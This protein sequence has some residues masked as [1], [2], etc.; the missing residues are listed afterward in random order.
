MTHLSDHAK[1][2]LITGLGVL[3]IT[4]DGLLTR[5]I[6]TDPWTLTFWRGLLSGIGMYLFLFAFYR[7][8]TWAKIRE[9]GQAGLV[10]SLLFGLGTI[11]FIFALNYTTVANTLFILNTSPIFAA[12]IAWAFMNEP[13][14]RRTWIV[15]LA[16]LMGIA[17]IAFADGQGMAGGSLFGNIIALLLAISVAINFSL[18]RQYKDRDMLPAIALGGF[19][20]ALFAL[21]FAQPASIS[22]SDAYYLLGMGLTMLPLSFGLMFIG[23]RYI[24][25]AEVSLMM[26]LEAI[27]GPLWVWLALGENPGLYTLLGGAIIIITL[28]VNAALTLVASNSEQ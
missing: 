3:V 13:V 26:L 24:P 15:I 7:A 28:A 11:A 23:P 19:V 2:L 27:L 18:T 21:P 14:P 22:P 4:P 16:V 1:G 17:I 6:T 9:I 25:A 8:Q 12:L 5:L 10:L 20:T